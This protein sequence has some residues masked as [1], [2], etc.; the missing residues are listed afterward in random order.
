MN[1]EGCSWDWI[2]FPVSLVV[3]AVSR[4]NDSRIEDRGGILPHCDCGGNLESNFSGAFVIDSN[5]K[6]CQ[7]LNWIV[8][9]MLNTSHLYGEALTAFAPAAHF[10]PA[11]QN[12]QCMYDDEMMQSS[13]V[14]CI[15]LNDMTR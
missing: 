6:Q 5:E 13:A 14:H 8:I 12:N 4:W 15:G 2:C 1:R 3:S 9:L 10:Y 11:R 7:S